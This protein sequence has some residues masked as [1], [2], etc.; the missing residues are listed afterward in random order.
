[1]LLSSYLPIDNAFFV[2]KDRDDYYRFVEHQKGCQLDFLGSVPAYPGPKEDSVLGMSKILD[3]FS[4]PHSPSFLE[5][6]SYTKNSGYL[7][8]IMDVSDVFHPRTQLN[9]AL[10]ESY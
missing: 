3:G 7:G 9:D 2:G 5:G 1:M 4:I 6:F 10:I 8:V